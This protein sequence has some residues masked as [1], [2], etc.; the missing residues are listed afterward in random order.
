MVQLFKEE[1][2]ANAQADDLYVLEPQAEATVPNKKYLLISLAAVALLYAAWF[3]YNESQNAVVEEPVAEEVLTDVSAP[4]DDFPLQVE[5][6]AT[7][8]ET[9]PPADEN[10]IA[11]VDVTTAAPVESSPQVTV[12][13][14][15]FVEP[16]TPAVQPE[17]PTVETPAPA[18]AAQPAAEAEKAPVVD[19]KAGSRVLLK[20]NK[21][22]WVE[23]KD[24]DKL[25]ISKVLQPGD[26]YKVPAGSGKILSVGRVDA[27]EVLIDGKVVP[28]VSAAKKTGIALDKFLDAN[29]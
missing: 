24:Q 29:H 21:E 8:D 14:A 15:S 27:V 1:T 7:L 17:T 5:D 4:A 2:D 13:E 26:T 28:V 12:S 20:I 3:A 10:E 11:V 22:T 9:V 18:E 16:E 25:W 19:T 23:V 6:F